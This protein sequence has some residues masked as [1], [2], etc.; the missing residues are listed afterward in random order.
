MY[1]EAESLKVLNPLGM[2]GIEF[3]LPLNEFE[4]LMV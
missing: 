4:G 1:H 2:A 3:M